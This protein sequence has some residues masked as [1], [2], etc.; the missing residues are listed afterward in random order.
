MEDLVSSGLLCSRLLPV[1]R[2]CNA[3]SEMISSVN[4]ISE[5]MFCVPSI[6]RVLYLGINW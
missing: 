2:D 1:E 3:E 6:L 5:Y 4:R